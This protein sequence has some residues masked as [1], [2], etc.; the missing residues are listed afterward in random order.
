MVA[1]LSEF[2]SDRKME[3]I[4][5]RHKKHK[6]DNKSC[7]PMQERL[8]LPSS[9]CCSESPAKHGRQKLVLFVL[10]KNQLY[11]ALPLLTPKDEDDEEDSYDLTCRTNHEDP[12]CQL[13]SLLESQK[14]ELNPDYIV[15]S[16][17]LSCLS[18]TKQ[19]IS[20]EIQKLSLLQARSQDASKLDLV[21]FYMELICGSKL[22]PSQHH[23]MR[24]PNVNWGRY[25]LQL[26]GVSLEES[27]IDC[28]ERLFKTLSMFRS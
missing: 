4:T 22:L 6:L 27:T 26:A 5:N 12:D 3:D 18:R 1:S 8:P 14:L 11:E 17:T 20:G 15:L 21:A 16:S 9:P 2:Y 25:S 13:D 24:A 7:Y 23:V 28:N 10:N 19:E